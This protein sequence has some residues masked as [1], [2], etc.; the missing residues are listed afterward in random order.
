[1]MGQLNLSRFA[2]S[3]TT[4]MAFR[5]IFYY[6][7]K[8]PDKYRKLMAEIDAADQDGKLSQIVKYK[9]GNELVYLYEGRY[10]K[11]LACHT[12]LMNP[13][14]A[15]FKEALRLHPGIGFLLERV[16]PPGGARICDEFLPGGTIVGM[17]AFVTHF[18]KE[19]YGEDVDA[20]R[21][22]RW[23]EAGPEQMRLMER[24]NLTVSRSLALHGPFFSRMME[25]TDM[26]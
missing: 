22:E 3:D 1:M 24:S 5:S 23:L 6:L 20:F 2:G 26:K 18:D 10:P 8:N 12:W 13:S 4:A 15:V 7:V 14:Q 19:V 16:V 17:Q 25:L 9:E 21:P 11:S